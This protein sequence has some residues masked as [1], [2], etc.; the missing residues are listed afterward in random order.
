MRTLPMSATRRPMRSPTTPASAPPSIMPTMPLAT[1]G[2][3]VAAR[4]GPVTHHRRDG[5][6]QQLVVD[7]VED[8]RQRRQQHEQL[9]PVAPMAFVE[10]LA[11]ID[12]LVL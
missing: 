5:D 6:A 1:I 10:Q 3:N 2:L 7:A 12:G 9:L 4:H 11:D 8:N